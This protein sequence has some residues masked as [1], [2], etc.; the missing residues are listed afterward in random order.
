MTVQKARRVLKTVIEMAGRLDA[1]L[2]IAN[3]LE[4]FGDAARVWKKHD[5][6]V[7]ELEQEHD[8]L[9]KKYQ[10]VAA[11][12]LSTKVE[13]IKVEGHAVEQ[14]LKIANRRGLSVAKGIF[15]GS[16]S[17]KLVQ[18]SERPVLV[19]KKTLTLVILRRVLGAC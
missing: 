19:V 1:G 8:A 18:L 5:S 6:I 11:K 14:I 13:M 3:V 7:K 2:L 16:V 4:D 12:Q 10:A 9:L 17:H 15:L